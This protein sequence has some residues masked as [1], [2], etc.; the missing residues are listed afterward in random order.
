MLLGI[1]V[2]NF[3]MLRDTQVGIIGDDAL[4]K[5][6]D[7][8]RVLAAGLNPAMP[9][10]QLAAFIGR[11]DTGK[12]SV[13]HAMSFLS[14]TVRHGVRFASTQSGRKGFT[15]LRSNGEEGPILFD[16]AVFLP[17]LDVTVLYRISLDCDSF[18]RPFILEEE[19][20]RAD[21]AG[22]RTVPVLRLKNGKGV[23][24]DGDKMRDAGVAEE[25]ATGLGAYGAI[26]AHP[27]IHALYAMVSNWFF[28]L[29]PTH[30]ET[31]PLPDAPTAGGH[32]HLSSDG[33][34]LENV[35]QYLRQA[36]AKS[37]ERA[38][39]RIREKMPGRR[40]ID[41]AVL[42]G[43]ISGATRRLF[44]YLLLLEDPQP[45]PLLCIEHPDEGLYHE[46]VD[47]LAGEL[48]DYSLRQPDTQILFT[49]HNPY[50]LESMVPEEVWVF[51]RQP[52]EG[53]TAEVAA[54]RD[55]L[56]DN[57]A[58]RCVGA[59]PVVRA[60]YEEGVGMG[61]MWYSGH[62]EPEGYDAP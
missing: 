49:T 37:Y 34:N 11:N 48:R 47:T 28:C 20:L 36:D 54:G 45:R 6:A 42:D 19:I 44:A 58:A 50:M 15:R 53:L 14:D 22:H 57:A 27:C 40:P 51:V 59:D 41:D 10:T 1:R 60:M 38:I 12:S 30:E 5:P 39:G 46:M 56:A 8:G 25:D 7:T 29:F 17:A 43:R 55:E 33:A 32:K 18:G 4:G 35:L 9:L 23:L 24:A 16:L 21:P 52:V 62:F 61:S 3:E 31:S 13:F 26:T 2:R